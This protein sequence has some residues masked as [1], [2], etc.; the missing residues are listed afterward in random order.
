M[1]KGF[2]FWLRTTGC[3]AGTYPQGNRWNEAAT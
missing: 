3:V 2:F 1:L